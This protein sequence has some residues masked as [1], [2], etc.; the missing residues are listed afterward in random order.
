MLDRYAGKLELIMYHLGNK[1]DVVEG[2]SV[3]VIVWPTWSECHI[4][5]DA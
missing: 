3:D 1:C 2:S 4:E 5:L